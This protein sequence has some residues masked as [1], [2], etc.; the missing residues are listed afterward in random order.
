MIDTTVDPYPVS[1]FTVRPSP[2][3]EV[4]TNFPFVV[5]VTEGALAESLYV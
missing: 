5:A 3:I 4:L 1:T 2:S